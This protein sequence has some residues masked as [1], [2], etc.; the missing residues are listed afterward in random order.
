[1][2]VSITGPGGLAIGSTNVANAVKGVATFSNLKF[3]TAGTY[4]LKFIDGTL[5]PAITKTITIVPAAAAKLAFAPNPVSGI[6]GKALTP[7]VMVKVEDT[8]GNVVT[9]N[10]STVKLSISSGPTGGTLTGGLSA[11]AFKGIVS[12]TNA[13]LK[14]A[15]AYRLKA[16]DGT[17]TAG[18]S[19]SI[20]ISAAS[21]AKLVI[22]QQPL[23]G[24]VGLALTPAIV[25]K[26]E[27]TFGNVVTT[28]ATLVTLSINSGP[29]GAT[30]GGTI[31]VNAVKGIATLNNVKPSK[32]GDYT[33]KA[34]DGVLAAAI[35]KQI[36]VS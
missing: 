31:K 10:T 7:A 33:L 22:T 13:V 14:T 26:V 4:T 30:L 12:F 27:D 25:V 34:I 1:V 21:A 11:N 32:T 20:T 6:A 3:N 35:S 16:T 29:I 19:G 17:L 36:V 15:G 2:A 24:K 8:F 18:I 28:N 23:V 9:T 5:A